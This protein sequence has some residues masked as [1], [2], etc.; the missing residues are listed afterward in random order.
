MSY[1]FLNLMSPFQRDHLLPKN[2]TPRW[3]V[4]LNHINYLLLNIFKY[5]VC[6]ILISFLYKYSYNLTLTVR[7]IALQNLTNTR[8]FP[9]YPHGYLR[10]V[11]V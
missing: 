4:N 1:M 11:S 2:M 7:S 6:L 8:G 9:S 3:S 10:F 5:N